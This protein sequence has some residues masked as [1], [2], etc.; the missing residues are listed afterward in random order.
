MRVA[1]KLTP[2]ILGASRS[3][4]AASGSPGWPRRPH[5]LAVHRD[6]VGRVGEY[7]VA[8]AAAA[9]RVPRAR[10]VVVRRVDHVAAP[11]A[12]HR[13]GALLAFQVVGALAA[14]DE[15]V[16]GVAEERRAEALEATDRAA[17]ACRPE[18]LVDLPVVTG[19][20]DDPVR[21][22]V[23]LRVVRSDATPENVAAAVPV[24]AELAEIVVAEP[25]DMRVVAASA[26]GAVVTGERADLIVVRRAGDV[27]VARG[28]GARPTGA[29]DRSAGDRDGGPDCDG[30]ADSVRM[31]FRRLMARMLSDMSG[32][33]RL[34]VQRHGR[35][36]EWRRFV[37]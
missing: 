5:P 1:G 19:A 35:G 36:Q 25:A 32:P 7:R 10:R 24:A 11:A 31:L 15:V 33:L 2:L 21:L 8:P 9:D 18:R 37:V 22:R 14:T 27:V 16:A 28:A 23:A 13:V 12:D 3:A 29:D 6:V 20:A 26:L 34:R 4:P 17:A 30:T